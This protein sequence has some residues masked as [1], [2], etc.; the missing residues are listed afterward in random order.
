MRQQ[1]RRYLRFCPTIC[2][3]AFMVNAQVEPE[4]DEEQLE[5][6]KALVFERCADCHT[7]QR[8]FSAHY[9]LA[10]WHDA[11]ERMKIEGLEVEPEEQ[12]DI[13]AYMATQEDLPT[14]WNAIGRLHFLILHF[15]IALISL[16][17]LFE[18]IAWLQKRRLARD[19]LHLLVRLA[20]CLSVPTIFFG[21]AL[22]ADRPTMPE[23]L[24]WHRNL[25]ILTGVAITMAWLARE[26]AVRSSERWPIYAYYG[27]L[28]VAVVA[29]A[30]TG[31]LGGGLVHG[32][33][34]DALRNL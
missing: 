29:V 23:M 5:R 16:L 27:A 22:A 13:V 26:L 30:I 25:G 18:I 33:L 10:G 28:A 7:L 17:G 24:Q 8:A 21:L 12:A 31:D 3:L 34:M 4:V 9:D 15:P 14:G 1:V 20:V 19:G 11:I 2:L 32:N 6:G